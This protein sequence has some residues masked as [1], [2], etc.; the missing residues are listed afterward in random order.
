ML[1]PLG[2]GGDRRYRAASH[3]LVTDEP[4]DPPVLLAP[5]GAVLVLDG[6]FLHR[7]E[8]AGCWA[9][10]VWLEVPFAVSV[11]RMAVRD[12]TS[13]DPDD[14]SVARHVEGQRLYL[15]ACAPAERADLVVDHADLDA[16]TLNA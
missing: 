14:P 9:L 3:G 5:A 10:S 13:P 4:R 7:D 1:D 16:P 2:P 8:L 6:V 15:A 12:G 11:A